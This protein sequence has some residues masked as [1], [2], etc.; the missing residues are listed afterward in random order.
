MSDS[1]E[2]WI[3]QA[4]QAG[5]SDDKITNQLT[6]NGWP[7]EQIE[8]YLLRRAPTPQEV[9]ATAPRAQASRED[10]KL[11]IKFIVAPF[12]V[13]G[14]ALSLWSLIAF[15]A[16]GSNESSS[17]MELLN[18][19]LGLIG[20]LCALGIIVLVPLGIYFLVRKR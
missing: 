11:G 6:Q 14:V 18:W 7:P 4:R 2:A 3:K 9:T 16:G 5:I 19:D 15:I 13:L 8:K 1:I 20:F 17:T 12:V 10:R